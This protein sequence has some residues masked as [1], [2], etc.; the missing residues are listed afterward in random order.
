MSNSLAVAMVTAALRRILG[1]ALVSVPAGGVENARVTTLRPNMLADVD[2]DARG[3][4]IFLFEVAANGAW[5]GADLPTRRPDGTLLTRPQQ[6]LN[7]NY[8]LTFSG[9][10]N[11]LEPQRMLGVAVS[12][13]AAQPVLSRELLLQIIARDQTDDPTTWEQFSD[14]ADQIDVVRFTLLPLNLEELSKLWSTFIQSPYRLSVT[15][16]AAVVLLDRDL[17]PQPAL[18]V[19]TRGVDA[20]AFQVPAITRVV[21][22]SAPTDPVVPGTT[23][24]IEGQRLRGTFTTRVRLDRVEVPVPADQ[25]TGTRLTVRLPAGVRAGVRAVQVVHPRLVGT[26]PVERAG[27]ESNAAA[28]IVRPVVTGPVTAAPG[29]APGVVD[30]TVPLDPPVGRRQRIVLTLN[31]HHPP[32]DRVGRAYTFVG[33]PRDPADP[34]TTSSD[35]VPVR[36]VV[37]GNYL[38]R[39]QVDGA[40]SVLGVGSD[41]RYDTPRVAIP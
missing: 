32:A 17:T 19:L 7:L 36:D 14:L 20:A 12:T 23:L 37:A 30:V 39:V 6:A 9:D 25:V 18:P 38:V 15:Y 31:E 8:L 29:G 5:T 1:E 3:I 16:Q 22:D 2:G 40:E 41:G 24:R 28:L 10:E 27:A 11:A 26:P 4:N 33:P 13:L 35:T 34:E 21:A